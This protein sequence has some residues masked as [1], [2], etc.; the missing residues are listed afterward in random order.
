MCRLSEWK[1]QGVYFLVF[2]MKHSAY[3]RLVVQRSLLSEDLIYKEF[4]SVGA[5]ESQVY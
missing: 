2:R 3:Y 4:C 5:A 1:K